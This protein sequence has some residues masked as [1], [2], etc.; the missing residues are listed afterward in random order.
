MEVDTKE[1]GGARDVR[2]IRERLDGLREILLANVV[3]ATEI[4]SPTGAE[5][6]LTRYL[7]DR[8]RESGL[9]D[10]ASD[11]VGNV[12]GVIPGRDPHRN[13]LVSAHTDKIWPTNADHSVSVGTSEFTGRGIGDNG[14]GVAA[15]ATLALA[16][17]RS[18]ASFGANLILLGTVSSHGRGDLAGM[19]FFLRNT[20][21]PIDAA[22]CIEGLGLGS[23]GHRCPGLWRGEFRFGKSQG[24]K[25]LD[26]AESEVVEAIGTVLEALRD[27]DATLKPETRVRIGSVEAGEGFEVAPDSGRIRFEIHGEDETGISEADSLL[28]GLLESIRKQFAGLECTLEQVAGRG[29]GG[30]PE[31]HAF[32]RRSFSVLSRLGLSPYSVASS[33]DLAALIERNI[34][35]LAIG[36]AEGS[37]LGTPRESIRPQGVLDGLAQVLALLEFMDDTEWDGGGR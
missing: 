19:R 10:I 21:R 4:P 34:P 31:S 16:I 15:L 36:A 6:E 23:I 30:L 3:M 20:A 33:S 5:R 27:A 7:A 18:G 28:A 26:S 32:V 1:E 14:A 22:L 8:F 25:D 12:A 35:A 37:G 13:L 17:E 29:P 11:A 24:R 9:S 2:E